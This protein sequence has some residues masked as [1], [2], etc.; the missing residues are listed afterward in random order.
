M[1]S[2]GGN[3]P[4]FGTAGRSREGAWIEILAD[5]TFAE[6][7]DSRSREGAWIEISIISGALSNSAV[8]PARERGL[9]YQGKRM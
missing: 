7:C 4:V 2:L 3:A 8:A 1:K 5:Q 6:E 9:K